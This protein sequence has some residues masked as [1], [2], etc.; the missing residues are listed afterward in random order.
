MECRTLSQLPQY[1]L[2]T[3]GQQHFAKSSTSALC[4]IYETQDYTTPTAGHSRHTDFVK[5]QNSRSF[6]LLFSSSNLFTTQAA[7]SA[8]R[9]T[10]RTALFIETYSTFYQT[11]TYAKSR[12]KMPPKKEVKQE[13]ILLGR[14]GNN[15]KSGIVRPTNMCVHCA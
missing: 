2:T 1:S 12:K 3:L 14:P 10:T 6:I 9:T 4:R 13:K 5:L 8:F 11:R 15:L 7:G